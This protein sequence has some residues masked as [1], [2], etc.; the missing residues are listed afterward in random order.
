M[1]AFEN[2]VSVRLGEYAVTRGEGRLAALGL[3]SC[4]ALIVH[5]DQTKV[6][7][8]AHIVLPSPTDSTDQSNLIKF[9]DTAVPF[10]LEEMGRAGA[11]H[12]RI[13]A[14]IIGGAS[15]FSNLMPK[16]ATTIG[17]RNVKRCR[18]LLHDAEVEI[19]AE[20]VG[21]HMGRSVVLDVSTG[22][23]TVRSVGEG[24]SLV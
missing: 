21:A 13:K 15:M 17:Q 8:I 2:V 9:A 24:E 6:G 14:R 4:V 5:D 1:T 20:A 10:L 19:L 7:G 23:V 16:S 11:V 18:E 3:G 22:T 12:S